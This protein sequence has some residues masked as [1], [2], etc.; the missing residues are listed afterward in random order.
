M[1]IIGFETRSDLFADAEGGKREA[2]AIPATVVPVTAS[3]SRRLNREASLRNA[4]ECT[5]APCEGVRILVRLSKSV[6]VTWS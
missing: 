5:T 6:T 2:T 4:R 3:T 1:D